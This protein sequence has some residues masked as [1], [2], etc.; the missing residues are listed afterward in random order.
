MC[1]RPGVHIVGIGWL[2][3]IWQSYLNWKL[4]FFGISS[5]LSLHISNDI[6]HF[7]CKGCRASKSKPGLGGEGS[8]HLDEQKRGGR[9][10]QRWR[11]F[12]HVAYVAMF[13]S[14]KWK[15]ASPGRWWHVEETSA[16]FNLLMA[17]FCA[18]LSSSRW[19]S[20]VS[21]PR[22]PYPASTP[23]PPACCPRTSL[24]AGKSAPSMTSKPPRTM[25][26]LSSRERSSPSWTTGDFT[27]YPPNMS[28]CEYLYRDCAS[29]NIE[30]EGKKREREKDE[31]GSARWCFC[32]LI[33][34]T[35]T[36]GRGKRT[37]ESDCFP[38]TLSQLISLQSLRWVS[39]HTHTEAIIAHTNTCATLLLYIV[40]YW[41]WDLKQNIKGRV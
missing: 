36:G 34:V 6:W 11:V 5:L 10:G 20:S 23:A 31:G 32:F 24:T 29:R 9:L 38:P 21:S 26:S 28:W 19:K 27:V 4:L 22:P 2:K 13:T 25:S 8:F 14:P 37:K 17:S 30:G 12:V 33:S 18:Q 15:Q 3:R 40:K 39:K 41:S 7:I 16:F 1:T 35:Q